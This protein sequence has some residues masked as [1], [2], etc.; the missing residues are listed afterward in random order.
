MSRFLVLTAVCF[1]GGV[2]LL[3]SQ[4]RWF[5]RAPMI[6]R[7]RP[8]SPGGLAL[9]SRRGALSVTS[10]RDVISPLAQTVGER[11]A[12]A[13]GV[14]EELETRLRRIHSPLTVAAF[15]TRQL[16]WSIAAFGSG[17]LVGLAALL[18]LLYGL[19]WEEE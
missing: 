9:P 8:Y 13:F 11:L 17:L 18:P 4:V 15:R 19:I 16:G 12:R 14:S 1:W 3:L 10:F 7:L 6:E 5:G 2:T